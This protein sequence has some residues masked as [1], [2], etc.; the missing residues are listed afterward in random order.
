MTTRLRGV[1]KV[2]A[3]TALLVGDG[4]G[5]KRRRS[6]AFVTAAAAVAAVADKPGPGASAGGS[7]AD[8][9]AQTMAGAIAAK[10][11]RN[12]RIT[13]DESRHCVVCHKRFGG[14]AIRVYPD[15]SVVHYGCLGS[16]SVGGFGGKMKKN[17][18]FGFD[19]F[20]GF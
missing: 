17:E 8:I 2:D 12:R 6:A 13:I 5:S 3:E 19:G 11:G 16:G 10:R 9:M 1:Q 4:L 15:S 18:T 20:G 7:A 14:S